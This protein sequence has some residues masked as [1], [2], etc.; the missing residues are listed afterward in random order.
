[1]NS[2]NAALVQALNDPDPE[3]RNKAARALR[4][5]RWQP[6]DDLER[7][8]FLVALQD[9]DE[10]KEIGFI[11]TEALLVAVN[12]K[13]FGIRRSA[14]SVLEDVIDHSAVYAV[15]T[16]LE[17]LSDY[18]TVLASGAAICLGRIRDWRA[19]APLLE[20]LEDAYQRY[21]SNRYEAGTVK[22][23]ITALGNIGNAKAIPLLKRLRAEEDRYSMDSPLRLD[24]SMA[25]RRI[26]KG[27][28]NE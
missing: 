26:Q 19:T 18:D 28:V 23:Y 21:R 25:I 1:M 10:V 6:R 27:G 24:L 15:T 2:Q 12:G 5:I 22:T 7:A 13:H 4:E 20:C 9:W 17:L 8:S 11:A 3:T 16:L 14:M